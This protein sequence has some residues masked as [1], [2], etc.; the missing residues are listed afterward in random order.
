[1]IPNK[2]Y[3]PPVAISIGLELIPIITG[4][5]DDVTLIFFGN[6]FTFEGEKM[7]SPR[8]FLLLYADLSN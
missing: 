5:L 4:C 6:G 8:R 7:L 2:N 3:S 1:M